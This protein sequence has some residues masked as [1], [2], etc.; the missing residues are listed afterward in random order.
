[1]RNYYLDVTT[2]KYW[3]IELRAD[4]PGQ[5]PWIP[6][7]KVGPIPPEQLGKPIAEID[8]DGAAKAEGLNI[9]RMV[10]IDEAEQRR[11]AE[12]R[13]RLTKVKRTSGRVEMP[14][15]SVTARSSLKDTKARAEAVLGDASPTEPPQAPTTGNQTPIEP[16]APER[17]P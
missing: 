13:P 7:R 14:G 4:A 6:D 1:M 8:F 12:G 16:D 17:V 15:V 3:A 2:G 5:E 11:L 9:A 10:L